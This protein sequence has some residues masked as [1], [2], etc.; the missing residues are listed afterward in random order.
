MPKAKKK[1]GKLF[2]FR[3]DSLL[4]REKKKVYIATATE[5]SP[6]FEAGDKIAAIEAWKNGAIIFYTYCNAELTLPELEEIVHFMKG[7][8]SNG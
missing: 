1:T 7:V 8:K 3:K 2:S 4:T 5:N 6:G